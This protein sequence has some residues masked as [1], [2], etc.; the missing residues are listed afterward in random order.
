[1][2]SRGNPPSPSRRK[3]TDHY[4][5]HH[6]HSLKIIIWPS[7]EVRLVLLTFLRLFGREGKSPSKRRGTS[8][9]VSC[10]SVKQF[11]LCSFDYM[12]LSWTYLLCTYLPQLSSS[13]SSISL[14]ASTPCTVLSARLTISNARFPPPRVGTWTTILDR[15]LTNL[16]GAR[17]DRVGRR[18]EEGISTTTYSDSLLDH[19][20]EREIVDIGHSSPRIST[21]Q[22]WPLLIS[23]P[24]SEY[25]SHSTS[26]PSACFAM[27]LDEC[28]VQ[29]WRKRSAIL[30]KH[31]PPASKKAE[32]IYKQ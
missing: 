32:S 10:P 19:W 21:S 8:P 1:M 7:P 15:Y 27:V 2:E 20:R 3:P 9:S 31:I 30:C 24:S 5:K 18:C 11:S 26:G 13:S 14:K 6:L 17:E 12:L 16:K 23:V 25:E 22:G 29:R 4:S 28:I